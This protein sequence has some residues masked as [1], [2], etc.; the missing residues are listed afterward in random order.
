MNA[1]AMQGLLD[2][3]ATTAEKDWKPFHTGIDCLPIYETPDGG[4]AAMLLR[5]QPGAHAPDHLHMGYEHILVLSGS[6]TDQR[7]HHPTGTLLINEPGSEHHV[8]SD[9]GCIVL[10]IWERRVKAM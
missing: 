10:A 6:Q 9:E 2:V 7:G 4:P 8:H 5:Y 3:V 1:I